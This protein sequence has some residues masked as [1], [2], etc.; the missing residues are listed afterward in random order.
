MHT[1]PA[2]LQTVGA[3]PASYANCRRRTNRSVYDLMRTGTWL[4]SRQ[5]YICLRNSMP[6]LK[7][8]VHYSIHN[9]SLLAV[10]LCQTKQ[11]PV[12]HPTCSTFISIF[13]FLSSPELSNVRLSFRYSYQFF[14]FISY[15]AHFLLVPPIS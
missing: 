3:N 15:F 5:S 4:M 12:S 10:I 13:T 11:S 14:I 6:V 2:T 9:S 7:L 1:V 8:H